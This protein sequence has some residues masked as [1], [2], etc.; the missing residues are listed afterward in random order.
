MWLNQIKRGSH[1]IKRRGWGSPKYFF[2]KRD[3]NREFFIQIFENF[4]IIK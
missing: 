1:K 4:S 3:N 2:W